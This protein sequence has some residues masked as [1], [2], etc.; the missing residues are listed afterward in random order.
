MSGY[1]DSD[2]KLNTNGLYGSRRSASSREDGSA[3]HLEFNGDEGELGRDNR[4]DAFPV[5]PVLK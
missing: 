3:R 2:G 1:C 5:R 4:H